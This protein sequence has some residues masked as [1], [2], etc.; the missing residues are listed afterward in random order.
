MSQEWWLTEFKVKNHVCQ[1]SVKHRM[2]V[3]TYVMTREQHLHN[4]NQNY[5]KARH[6]SVKTVYFILRTI[7]LSWTYSPILKSSFSPV[8]IKVLCFVFFVIFIDQ[9]IILYTIYIMMLLL[10]T[11]CAWV[12]YYN[13]KLKQY[14]LLCISIEQ[15]ML[16]FNSP[17]EFFELDF[18]P[19]LY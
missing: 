9:F 2:L 1:L 3:S 16:C 4:Q 10:H 7:V 17:T 5:K 8:V 11:M 19:V 6:I 14:I 18:N 15:W 13:Y 12:Y